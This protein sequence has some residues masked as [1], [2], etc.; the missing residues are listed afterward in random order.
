MS[1]IEFGVKWAEAK[2]GRLSEFLNEGAVCFYIAPEAMFDL[3]KPCLSLQVMEV[4]PLGEVS[5]PAK[6]ERIEQ[7]YRVQ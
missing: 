4:P 1:S 6:M 2:Q 7:P 5:P 3:T